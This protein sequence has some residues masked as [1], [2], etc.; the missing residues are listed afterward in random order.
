MTGEGA[1]RQRVTMEGLELTYRPLC[2][3]KLHSVLLPP[4]QN[5][6]RGYTKTT[7]K[8]VGEMEAVFQVSSGSLAVT[9]ESGHWKAQS[10]SG[11]IFEKKW[12]AETMHDGMGLGVSKVSSC[13]T[14][15]HHTVL[16]SS[17]GNCLLSLSSEPGTTF[18]KIDK[19]PTEISLLM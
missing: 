9:A 4:H 13:I 5:T 1:K 10:S 11:A 7:P 6:E 8:N 15:T 19:C 17:S 2:S 14:E 3:P 16:L 12:A 18:A